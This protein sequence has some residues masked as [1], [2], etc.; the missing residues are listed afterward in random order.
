MLAGAP[1][2]EPGNG[3]IKIRLVRVVCQNAFQ[4]NAEIELVS[5]QELTTNFGIKDLNCG[6]MFW[7]CPA[8]V[9]APFPIYLAAV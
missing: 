1:G 7:R 4:K 2:F 9:I 6:C 8:P 5:D 3:G